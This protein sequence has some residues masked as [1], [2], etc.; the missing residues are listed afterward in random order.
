MLDYLKRSLDRREPETIAMRI[1]PAFDRL[2]T[3]PQFRELVLRAGT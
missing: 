2:R 3:E 1:D